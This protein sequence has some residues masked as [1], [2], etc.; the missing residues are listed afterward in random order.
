MF[1]EMGDDILWRCNYSVFSVMCALYMSDMNHHSK[2]E[3]DTLGNR[4]ICF[5]TGSSTRRLDG[6]LY[7][8]QTR[9]RDRDWLQ[10]KFATFGKNQSG[11]FFSF[12]LKLSSNYNH[13]WLI[14]L[15][16]AVFS[17]LQKIYR[18]R[19]TV[20]WLIASAFMPMSFLTHIYVIIMA[21][22]EAWVWKEFDYCTLKLLWHSL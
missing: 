4:L 18:P 21:I 16:A 1:L 17:C 3:L 12:P 22:R 5:Q 8:Q 10:V 7:A 9:N 6:K 20:L 19:I 2:Q 15:R 11:N 14:K 13:N